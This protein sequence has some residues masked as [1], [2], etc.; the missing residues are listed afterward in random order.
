[1][2]VRKKQ[3]EVFCYYCGVPRQKIIAGSSCPAA[4]HKCHGYALRVV[5]RRKKRAT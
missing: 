4:W 5:P 2:V 3:M 1:M